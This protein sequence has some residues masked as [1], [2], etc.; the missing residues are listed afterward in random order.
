M[1]LEILGDITVSGEQSWE[2]FGFD[3]A[4]LI[5]FWLLWL[6][7]AVDIKLKIYFVRVALSLIQVLE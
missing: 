1:G 4:S 7:S 3:S 6:S 2:Q 5:N